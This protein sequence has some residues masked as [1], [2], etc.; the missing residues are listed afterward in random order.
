MEG[1]T[2]RF[3]EALA[4]KFRFRYLIHQNQHVLS[5]CLEEMIRLLLE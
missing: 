2:E 1:E 5:Y 4:L 3:R